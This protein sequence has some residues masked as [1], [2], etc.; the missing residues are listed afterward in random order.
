MS[1]KEAAPKVTALGMVR[2]A[3][4]WSVVE[5]EIQGNQAKVIHASNPDMKAIAEE[6]FRIQV[7]KKIFDGGQQ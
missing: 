3:D 6:F 2:M 7:V 4:G 5:F 1:K